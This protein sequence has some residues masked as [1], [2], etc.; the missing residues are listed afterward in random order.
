MKTEVCTVPIDRP[1]RGAVLQA[2][3][4][5]RNKRIGEG[6]TNEVLDALI[7]RFENAPFK[8]GRTPLEAR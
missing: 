8:K 1:E 7:T 3:Y 6:K 2:L 5:L 4:D